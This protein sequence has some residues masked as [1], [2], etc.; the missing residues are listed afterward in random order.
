MRTSFLNR[1]SQK[2]GVLVVKK[3]R[4]TNARV[5]SAVS[6][7]SV[8]FIAL[9]RGPGQCLPIKKVQKPFIEWKWVNEWHSL[10]YI[11]KDFPLF[12]GW[13]LKT[14]TWPTKTCMIWIL[15]TSPAFH[16]PTIPS[17]FWLQ[18]C[19]LSSVPGTFQHLSR[20]LYMP[21]PLPEMFFQVRFV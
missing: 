2:S 8:L 6:F 5:Q 19:W 7:T 3:R 17:L 1:P 18:L 4:K 12:V 11:L 15:Y 10:A 16:S 20:S 9:Y 13:R 14:L 21:F